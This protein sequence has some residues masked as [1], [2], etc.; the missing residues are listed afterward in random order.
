MPGRRSTYLYWGSLPMFRPDGSRYRHR[1]NYDRMPIPPEA[2]G[3]AT[4][5]D[6]W[7][8]D[9]TLRLRDR[10]RLWRRLRSGYYERRRQSSRQ[11]A[12]LQRDSC[13]ARCRDGHACRARTAINPHTGRLSRRCRM[14]GGHSTGPRTEAGRANS[15]AAL[16]RARTA[17]AGGGQPNPADN[18]R[19]GTV[20]EVF[21][22]TTHG[23][24]GAAVPNTPKAVGQ[25]GI[26]ADSQKKQT[27]DTSGQHRA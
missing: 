22:P 1:I 12:K 16:H 23:V 9:A 24:Q 27:P 11:P 19:V 26:S 7:S 6:L 8:T 17:R 5:A 15:L 13:G 20:P 21:R 4:L 2:L 25:G 10:R 3:D 18:S 14:H